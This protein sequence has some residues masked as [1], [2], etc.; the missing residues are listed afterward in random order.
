MTR[1][2]PKMN[3]SVK[4]AIKLLKRDVRNIKHRDLYTGNVF[5]EDTCPIA[6]VYKMKEV[7][8]D[9]TTLHI[10]L[11]DKLRDKGWTIRKLHSFLVWHDTEKN[12]TNSKGHQ[13]TYF[14]NREYLMGILK[15]EVKR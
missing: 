1:K 5:N 4:E 12:Y 10:L 3:K 14:P 7:A 11:D 2:V 13:V 9:P 15:K 8:P 6:C